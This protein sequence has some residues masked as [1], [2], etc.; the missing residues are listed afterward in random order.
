MTIPWIPLFPD[1]SSPVSEVLG[2]PTSILT[3]SSGREQRVRL[4]EFPDREFTMRMV[5]MGAREVAHLLYALEQGH[6][7]NAYVPFWPEAFQLTT[8]HVA[9]DVTLNVD[10]T[11]ERI[12]SF[13][14]NI[15]VLIWR[16]E[17]NVAR[18]AIT[19]DAAGTI[20]IDPPL[21]EAWATGTW[22]VP[23][24][25]CKIT[26]V[27]SID[28]A[29]DNSVILESLTA[30]V[31]WALG[32]RNPIKERLYWRVIAPGNTLTGSLGATF[33]GDFWHEG[34]PH[35]SP[36][37]TPL[38]AT[39]E[40]NQRTLHPTKGVFS[41][42]T[43]S[44]ST[45]VDEGKDYSGIQLRLIGAAL[46][47][48]TIPK[49]MY[50]IAFRAIALSGGVTGFAHMRIG[51]FRPSTSTVLAVY[52]DMVDS[53]SRWFRFSQ[54]EIIARIWVPYEF[55]VQDGDRMFLDV[56]TNVDVASG[57]STTNGQ[58]VTLY[59]NGDNEDIVHGRFSAVHQTAAWVEVP[60]LKYIDRDPA[61]AYP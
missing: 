48:Q 52:E 50:R 61:V 9:T 15:E 18:Y 12:T 5:E 39:V 49:W 36:W 17:G 46:Q 22:I 20:D 58:G 13:G 33:F 37:L 42:L 4:R 29:T 43:T 34:K 32:R 44:V 2:Y 26:A 11:T 55:V 57:I 54:K 56:I 40:A 41:G 7:F 10:R 6:D 31:D 35:V 60:K 28:R 21:N 3:S 27:G 51:Y 16:G 38:P 14:Q 47:A 23:L 1:W 24:L 45:S 30:R 53:H 25:A 59:Y 19:G 8:D